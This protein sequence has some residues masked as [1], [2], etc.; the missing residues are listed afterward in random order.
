MNIVFYAQA[1]GTV[2]IFL[3]YCLLFWLSIM[4]TTTKRILRTA[5]LWT[6]TYIFFLFVLRA[7]NLLH[8]GTLDQLR[9]ISGFSSVIPLLAIIVHLFLEKKIN[10]EVKK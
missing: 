9:I 10:E 3:L 1:T 4:P 7:L 5:I 8:L 6:T 2:A